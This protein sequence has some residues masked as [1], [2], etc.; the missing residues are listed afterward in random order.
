MLLM[1][2][3][4]INFSD[5]VVG[6]VMEIIDQMNRERVVY[7]FFYLLISFIVIAISIFLGVFWGGIRY[8]LHVFSVRGVIKY[9]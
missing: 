5:G 1:F 2:V 4:E 9:L 3:I 6:G 7:Y 8:T